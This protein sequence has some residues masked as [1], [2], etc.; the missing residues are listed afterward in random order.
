MGMEPCSDRTA[1]SRSR[2]S[3]GGV[4]VTHP[5]RVSAVDI[6]Q[7]T[8]TRA[9]PPIS[10]TPWSALGVSLIARHYS[11]WE[12]AA[13]E[14][15]VH[16]VNSTQQA[17]MAKRQSNKPPKKQATQKAADDAITLLTADHRRVEELFAQ[18]EGESSKPAKDK[19]VKQVCD[20][21]AM[22]ALLEEELF[23][24]ACRQRGV[25]EDPLDEAQVEHDAVKI[26]V[27]DLQSAQDGNYHDAKVTVLKEYVSHHVA[28]EEQSRRGIFARARAAGLDLGA[29][30]TQIK[31][32][33]QQLI[34]LQAE[35]HLPQPS[36]KAIQLSPL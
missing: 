34:Q 3:V 32:R 33:K 11:A 26:L 24:A 2:R 4:S 15:E 1:A 22:H 17:S 20:E 5:W 25:E 28:E 31:E 36:P 10:S 21:L 29:L 7:D 14:S 9:A 18:W 27:A 12:P 8:A 19:L 16:H 6:G 13:L 35:G 30:G 23:Y